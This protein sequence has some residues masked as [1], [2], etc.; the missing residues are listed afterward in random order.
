VG[1]KLSWDGNAEEN[2]GWGTLVDAENPGG[3]DILD[4]DVPEKANSS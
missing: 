4:L 3:A 2:P 1:F